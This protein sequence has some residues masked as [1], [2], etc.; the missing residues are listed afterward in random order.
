MFNL[1]FAFDASVTQIY[2]P[3][4][5]GATIHLMPAGSEVDGLMSVLRRKHQLGFLKLTPAVFSLLGSLLNAE[6]A[7][8]GGPLIIL[9]GEALDA[10][11]C[12]DWHAL[13]PGTRLVN[14]YGPT[15]TVVGC[16]IH[17]TEPTDESNIP[18]GLPIWN[19]ELYILDGCLEPVLNS[20]TGELY[21]GGAGVARGYMGRS[22][23][24]AER[25]IASPYGKPGARLYRT[26]DLVRRRADGVIEFL[27]RTDT[28]VKVRGY[29]IEL[30]EVESTLVSH[31]DVKQATVMCKP[32]LDENNRLLAYVVLKQDESAGGGRRD[33]DAVDRQIGW[34]SLYDQAY[35]QEQP[36]D[37]LFNT[38]GWSSSYTR[39]QIPNEQM[40]R[41]RDATVQRITA[42][43]PRRVWEIGCGSGLLLWPLHSA[44]ENYFGSDLSAEAVH[45]LRRLV[46]QRQIDNVRVEHRPAND[47]PPEQS[48]FDV[49]VINSVVQYFPGRDYLEQ[50][51]QGAMAKASHGV[52]VGDVRALPL[53]R[54]FSTSVELHNA[55]DLESV[56]VVARRVEQQLYSENEL[57]V[58]PELF[59]WLAE[60]WDSP[61][62]VD[63]QVKR[64][65]DDN[66]MASYRYDVTL[67]HVDHINIVTPDVVACWGGLEQMLH[68]LRA[69]P[70]VCVEVRDI[71]NRRVFA[72]VWASNRLDTF[73]GSVEEL[74]KLAVQASWDAVDPDEIWDLGDRVGLHTRVTWST[75][76]PS[77]VHALF[78][79]HEC[80][81]WAWIPDSD[82]PVRALVTDPLRGARD[83]KR[84]SGL[85]A[86]LE[87][88][89]PGYMIPEV[90]V[91]LAAL[92]MTGNGKV[93]RSALPDSEQYVARR[94]YLPPRTPLEQALCELYAR[95]TEKPRIG[96]HDNFFEIGGHSLSAMRLIA[97][98]RQDYQVEL[99]L[100]A[101]FE[102]P[103]VS[104]LAV[105]LG[106]SGDATRE[107][108]A[109]IPL[110]T[111]GNRTPIFCFHP[112]G[113]LGTVYGPLAAACGADQ[114]VYAIQARGIESGEEPHQSLEEMIDCYVTSI[115]SMQPHGPYRLLGWSFGGT[116]AHAAAV[117][118]ERRGETV[119]EV[120]L[121]DTALGQV[122]T[123]DGVMPTQEDFETAFAHQV[124]LDP[125]HLKF[126]E[127][128]TR[129]RLVAT[130]VEQGLV[131]PGT[132]PEIIERIWD[133]LQ[134]CQERLVRH[135]EGVCNAHITLVKAC[136]EPAGKD[137]LLFDWHAHTNAACQVIKV[138][139][140]HSELLS[141]ASAECIASILV[142]SCMRR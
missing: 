61:V 128:A 45:V 1:S 4:L 102:C 138:P 43:C 79:H 63:I 112:G 41:W 3:L 31:A 32:A 119:S 59:R 91:P 98:I 127:P 39:A 33:A 114:P 73:D 14:E 82:V 124:G 57:L 42:L 105:R 66:E 96:V 141:C 86:D 47:F 99:P 53:Q 8:R 35:G 9:G 18:I 17:Q 48:A 40:A 90:I 106:E 111:S 113:G 131:P 13:A 12:R 46:S 94:A 87:R 23:L 6:Q 15:E 69:H 126:G 62:T 60:Q 50:V 89:L 51:L 115:R 27:G 129:E 84:V 36:D 49:V 123:A 67:R 5:A 2:L 37:P 97:A 71:P 20:V 135:V 24:T 120:I 68:L 65:G 100:R 16:C 88:S 107:Y 139:F 92:P 26:G 140:L 58:A 75:A 134:L 81:A 95:L 136:A 110:R 85:R 118:I 74:K 80:D 103:T 10:R 21:I 54:A 70:G 30:G 38:V 44:V 121:L 83:A 78:M 64:G 7:R 55:A 28:Q 116:L 93:D 76:D 109:V 22:G 130:A 19:A 101:I 122:R 125:E 104:E 142:N 25:F 132:A 108:H 72:D 133:Q 52:F 11:N 56:R 34:E 137:M 77:C 117:E 29:R